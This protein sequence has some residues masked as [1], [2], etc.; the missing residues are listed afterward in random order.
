M[1]CGLVCGRLTRPTAAVI[2][3]VAGLL[4]SSRHLICREHTL[5]YSPDLLNAARFRRDLTRAL[6]AWGKGEALSRLHALRLVRDEVQ[7]RGVEGSDTING[8]LSVA[9]TDFAT[10]DPTWARR[11][12]KR[13]ALGMGIDNVRCDPTEWEA[14]GN[15]EPCPGRYRTDAPIPNAAPLT[16]DQF[17]QRQRLAIARFA[18]FLCDKENR[19]RLAHVAQLQENVP[20]QPRAVAPL[21]RDSAAAVTEL[22][23]SRPRHLL[24]TGLGGIGKTTFIADVVLRLIATL[25]FD[26]VV[27]VELE[28]GLPAATVSETVYKKLAAGLGGFEK[29][30]SGDALRTRVHRRLRDEAVVVVID[31]VESAAAA[32]IA[33]DL[34]YNLPAP[35]RTLL[36]TRAWQPDHRTFHRRLVRLAPLEDDVTRALALRKLQLEVHPARAHVQAHLDQIVAYSGGHPRLTEMIIAAAR[37]HPVP[38]IVA[39]LSAIPETAQMLTNVHARLWRDLSTTGRDTLCALALAAERGL[40]LDQLRAQ[41]NPE[42]LNQAL[43]ELQ[44]MFL[45]T[46]DVDDTAAAMVY[47]YRIDDVTRQFLE[48]QGLC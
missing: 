8:V 44:R 38:E 23:G 45:V 47:R 17:K 12:H 43:L 13:F 19:R 40:T 16:V 35:T 25:T 29:E 24:V 4:Q 20:G 3:R 34:L 27:W 33:A 48:S 36:G 1:R 10:V 7:R 28:A 30:L 2:V 32:G 31:N 14:D 6:Q 37:R 41:V 9:L 42:G 39:D 15:A 11:L 5:R 46:V 21:G 18:E 22:A 26:A